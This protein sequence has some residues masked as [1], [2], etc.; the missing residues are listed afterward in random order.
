MPYNDPM[1][2]S[3]DPGSSNYGGGYSDGNQ[4]DKDWDTPSI[5]RGP[6]TYSNP[7]YTGIS[8]RRSYGQAVL[9]GFLRNPS[10]V[11]E[12]L[13]KK[14]RSTQFNANGYGGGYG[15]VERDGGNGD[16]G[17]SYTWGYGVTGGP[18]MQTATTGTNAGGSIYP[19]VYND[20]VTGRL[21]YQSQSVGNTSNQGYSDQQMI[22]QMMGSGVASQNLQQQM[23]LLQSTIQRLKASGGDTSYYEQELARLQGLGGQSVD[24]NNPLMLAVNSGLQERVAN[25]TLD[26][27]VNNQLRAGQEAN[28][29]RGIGTLG[30]PMNDQ[31]RASLGLS[32]AQA[33]NQNRMNAQDKSLQN[34]LNITGMLKN[35]QQQDYQQEMGR[36]GIGMQLGDWEN[37]RKIAEIAQA[38]SNSQFGQNMDSMRDQQ[39]DANRN[40]WLETIGG[41]AGSIDWGSFF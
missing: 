28:A 19:S 6:G 8:N 36:T 40:A 17:G 21:L 14:D 32:T 31:L 38:N 26:N 4:R 24:P 11:K 5:L 22:D 25:E 2:D 15:D 37:Q 34:R 23:G 41:V 13:T 39:S 1:G 29:R 3:G 33:R 20:P 10:M 7:N 12:G 16:R 9:G 18:N 35:S 30:S 27:S